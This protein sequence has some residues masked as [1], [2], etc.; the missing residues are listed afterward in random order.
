M[1]RFTQVCLGLMVLALAA[2]F[3]WPD[4]SPGPQQAEPVADRA[5]PAGP[6]AASKSAT[7]TIE[8]PP[9]QAK[10]PPSE[11]TPQD[12]RVAREQLRASILAQQ[13][14]RANEPAPARPDRAEPVEAAAP[15]GELRNRIGGHEDLLAQLNTDFM[16]LA[17]ECID[18]ARERD[19]DLGGMLTVNVEIMSDEELGSIVETVEFGDQDGINDEELRT[20]IRETTLSMILPE[21][22]TGQEQFM[23][24]LPLE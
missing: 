7:R 18:A 5:D 3:M 23:L 21:A 16:P 1:S 4:R 13:A 19:P 12:A 9:S 2:L 10:A 20:C 14:R 17:G 11:P 8:R 22:P 6:Q 24:T 15:T